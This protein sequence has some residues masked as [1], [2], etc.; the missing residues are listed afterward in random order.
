MKALRMKTQ[1]NHAIKAVPKTK[2]VKFSKG[3]FIN[4]QINIQYMAKTIMISDEVYAALTR[5]KFAGESYTT[6][7]AKCI[8]MGKKEGTLLE[9][10]GLWK[11]LSK[12]ETAEMKR[13]I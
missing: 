2:W 6:L 3:D 5:L 12:E 4:I 10:A 9:C 11:H 1:H 7:I 8:G 13:T